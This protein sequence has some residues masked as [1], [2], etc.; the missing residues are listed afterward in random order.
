MKGA[1]MRR[2]VAISLILAIVTGLYLA[3][4]YSFLLFHSLVELFSVVIAFGIFMVAWNSRNFIG[5]NY[6]LFMGI[7]YFFIGSIDC[8][9]TLAYK[10]MNIFTASGLNLSAQLWVAGRYMQGISML[11]APFFIRKTANP[12]RVFVIFFIVTSGVF[13]SVF[14]YD[15]FPVAYVEG[16]GLTNFKIMSEYIIIAILIAAIFALIR[17]QEYFDRKVLRLI[18]ASI[19]CAVVSELAFTF[20]FDVYDL[21]NLIGHYF[22]LFSY[23]IMYHATIKTGL[24]KPYSIILRDLKQSEERLLMEKNRVETYMS[25]AG[26]LFMIVDIS[27]K[28]ILI[29][30][31]G[32]EILNCSSEEIVGK[33]W[34]DTFVPAAD[35]KEERSFFLRF[36]S[37]M[38]RG[39]E[40]R[41]SAVLAGEGR[42]RI[43]AWHYTLLQDESGAVTGVLGS[44]EDITDR[45]EYEKALERYQG[46]LEQLVQKRTEEL[47]ST[48]S[49]L[50][51]VTKKLAEAENIE[52]QRI[53]R[54]LHDL[55]GQ[56]LTA[57]G[58]NLNIM[59]SKLSMADQ[60]AIL[61]RIS[62]SLTLV[63]ET[64]VSIRDV[65]SRLRPPVLD[66]YGL[67]A[68]IRWYAGQFRERTMVDVDVVGEELAPRPGMHIETALFR[69]VQEAFNNV[70]KHSGATNVTVVLKRHAEG[71]TL[72]IEDN[73]VG[74]DKEEVTRSKRTGRWGLTNISERAMSMGGR[75]QIESV[76]GRGTRIVVE[77][78]P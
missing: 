23:Y 72:T 58:L 57:L 42:E 10:G 7:A 5:N 70:I 69:I 26:V 54:E 40:Y 39:V 27:E 52:R 36:L 62:D 6:L 65:M 75:C 67:F 46:K 12:Q 50:I 59:R 31:R 33:D 11:A 15:V 4:L 68:A 73:G 28:V 77:V 60:E 8:V 44:G 51:A 55:I 18:A 71:V 21:S 48:N 32:C 38:T 34:F 45:I 9:H 47:E 16:A 49:Q 41:E 2:F 1:R 37:D 61:K 22:K 29:N 14:G 30:K 13:V 25:V 64:T 56:N 24:E 76:P 3:S 53:A 19:V 17:Q 35:R 66:D 74:F 43:I 63:E 20:Y 78:Q